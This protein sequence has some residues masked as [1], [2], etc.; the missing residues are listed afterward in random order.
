MPDPGAG[1][2]GIPNKDKTFLESLRDSKGDDWGLSSASRRLREL[3]S[4]SGQDSSS[5]TQPGPKPRKSERTFEVLDQPLP[6]ERALQSDTLETPRIPGAPGAPQRTPPP[7]ARPS[8]SPPRPTEERRLEP[9][10]TRRRTRPPRTR[11]ARGAVRRVKR[12]VKRVDP[13]SV[14]KMSLFYYAIF[15]VVWMIGVAVLFSFIE[16][17][18]VFQTI[19]EIGDGMEVEE[20][21]NFE[22][23]MGVVLR[24][25]AYIGGGLV[26]L[27]SVINV[28]L[29]FLYN[30]GSDIVGGVEMT[31]V[32]RDE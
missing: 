18:G 26:L 17:T 23:S 24:W 14:L 22:I 28:I 9:K 2:S 4:K 27:A 32:E 20:L 16:S 10:R 29:A 15:F 6:S 19:E 7:G 11:P 13:W 25:A 21:A 5:S 8:G 31:F 12:T 30:L 1:S 3:R